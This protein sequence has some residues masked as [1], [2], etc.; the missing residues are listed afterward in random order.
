M[1]M[2]DINWMAVVITLLVFWGLI[3][4]IAKA[5][6]RSAIAWILLS[7]LISPLI[8]LIVIIFMSRVIDEEPPIQYRFTGSAELSNDSYQIYLTKKYGIEKNDV[9][10]KFLIGDK[11]FSSVN[12]ALEY[13]DSLEK[14]EIR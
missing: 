1:A 9:L 2:D 6:N 14:K 13:A 11:S 7:L 5:K 3:A 10:S 4:I 8:T 12:D